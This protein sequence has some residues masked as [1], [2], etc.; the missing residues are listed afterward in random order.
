MNFQ[1]N[2]GSLACLPVL[3]R[4]NYAYWKQMMEI[5]LTAIEERFQQCILTRYTPPTKTNENSVES[6]KTVREWSNNELNAS[7][8]N[9]KGLNTIVNEVDISQY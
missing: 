1:I 4:T 6:P 3:D 7:R 2:V 5:Y 9:A 8:Y